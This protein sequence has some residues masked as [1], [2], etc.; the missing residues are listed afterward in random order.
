MRAGAFGVDESA[1][2]GALFVSAGC[3]AGG[4]TQC[5]VMAGTGCAGAEM[6]RLSASC[7]PCAVAVRLRSSESIGAEDSLSLVYRIHASKFDI[8]EVRRA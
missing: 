3:C 8:F 6:R 5:L 2:E 7:R 4:G 1:P